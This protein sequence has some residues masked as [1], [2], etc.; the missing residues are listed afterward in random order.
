MRLPD[1]LAQVLVN[2]GY[3]TTTEFY[4]GHDHGGLG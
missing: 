4:H 2:C 3:R 1:S